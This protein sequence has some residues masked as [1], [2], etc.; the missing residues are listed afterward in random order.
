MLEF[1]HESERL[2][3]FYSSLMDKNTNYQN[4][5]IM[6]HGNAAVDSGF[7]INKAMLIENMHERSV[8][9]LRTVYDAVSSSGELFK[10][11]ITKQMILAAR[12]AHSC[13]HEELK[14]KKK[15]IE[16]KSEE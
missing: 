15:I 3:V 2:D 6:L 1:K 7:G 14:V 9:A 11:N 16:K 5:L 4:V 10:V 12:N 8:I 13:C